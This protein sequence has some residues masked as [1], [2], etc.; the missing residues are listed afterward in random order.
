VGFFSLFP[1]WAFTPISS[2]GLGASEIV[3]GSFISARAT[4]QFVVLIPFAYFE[5]R[6]GV[7]RLYAYSVAIFTVSS[8]IGFPLL[9]ALA[10]VKGMNSPQFSLAIIIYF[11]L[12]RN[13]D[14]RWF[15]G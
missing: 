1:L 2:G 3:I 6:L 15:L 10:Q 5:T 8:A 12:V 14:I 9:N 7:Y 11:I 4:A 13:Q